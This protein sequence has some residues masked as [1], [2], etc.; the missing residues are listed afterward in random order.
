M[1]VVFEAKIKYNH[2]N[3]QWFI[4]LKDT[5]EDEVRL[6]YSLEEFE[7][8]IEQ[9]G[10]EYGGYIDEVK[11]LKDDDVPPQVL[12]EIRAQMVEIRARIEENMDEPLTPFAIKKD[13]K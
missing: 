10:S 3:K 12:D 7:N 8:N 2:D 13:S 4:E 6:C 11:W 5:L 9:M 1:A